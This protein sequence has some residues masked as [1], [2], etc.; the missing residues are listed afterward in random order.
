M[1]GYVFEYNAG[2]NVPISHA[3]LGEE[4]TG[5]AEDPNGN[6]Y[7][8]Y[9]R[10]IP[11]PNGSIAEFAPGLT[12]EQRL[13]M[14]INK[15][16]GLLVDSAGNIVVAQSS[17]FNDDIVVFAPGATKASVGVA[18]PQGDPYQLAMQNSETA[19]WVS[20]EISDTTAYVYYMPYPL[21]ASTQ[22]A[23]YEFQYV[24]AHGL[25]V[26]PASE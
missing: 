23:Q 14:K 19:L 3:R 8:A 21:R 24:F 15:P 25:A 20:S 9:W 4:A 11:R 6:L 17:P 5:I 1:Q 10:P 2:S 16:E 22:P 18:V 7:V 13:G 12:N 26:S